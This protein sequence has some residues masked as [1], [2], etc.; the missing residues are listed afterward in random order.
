MPRP[1]RLLLPLLLFGLLAGPALAQETGYGQ[2]TFANT[3]AEAA[4]APFLRG[5]LMLHSFEYDEARAAFQEAQR[6]DPDFAM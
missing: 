6:I 1:L 3:G 4:Q 5:L 2:T